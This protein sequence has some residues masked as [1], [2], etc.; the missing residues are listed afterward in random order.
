MRRILLSAIAVGMSA[1]AGI[2]QANRTPDRAAAPQATTLLAKVTVTVTDSKFVLS[3]KSAKRGPVTFK[4]TNVGKLQ[5]NFSIHGRKTR[6]LSHGKSA[7]LRVT[8][9]RKG[10]YAYKS[11]QT[12]DAAK[13]LTGI[14]TIK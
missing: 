13:G 4:V 9:L 7:T 12:G 2:A 3:A 8:F 11:T 14:F 1:S 10:A 6:L 5:H